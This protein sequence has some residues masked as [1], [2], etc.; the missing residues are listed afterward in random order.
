MKSAWLPTSLMTLVFTLPLPS[1]ADELDK[2]IGS[3]TSKEDSFVTLKRLTFEKTKDGRTKMLG[4]LVGFP[5]EVSIGEAIA[6]KSSPNRSNQQAE[7]FI[8]TFSSEKY[9][10]FIVVTPYSV[11]SNEK[12]S[13]G[14]SF[15]CYMTNIDGKKVHF[16]GQ[17]NREP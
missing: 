14:L 4:A 13:P 6:E 15:T 11:N 8:A 5:E 16:S 7:L 12:F 9:K 1:S 17:L 2:L 3:Y 10:P